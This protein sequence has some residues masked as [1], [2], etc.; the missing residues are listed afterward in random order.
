MMYV[1]PD[2]DRKS[3]TVRD[4]HFLIAKKQSSYLSYVSFLITLEEEKT[5]FINLSKFDLD[6]V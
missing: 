1:W 3:R 2:L 6:N 5:S 4:T